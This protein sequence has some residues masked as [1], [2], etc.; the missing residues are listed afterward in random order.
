VSSLVSILLTLCTRD[1]LPGWHRKPTSHI[2][3]GRRLAGRMLFAIGQ[4]LVAGLQ[5]LLT[6]VSHQLV[7][8]LDRL[9]C[10][11]SFLRNLWSQQCKH[12]SS[13]LNLQ[14]GFVKLQDW[15]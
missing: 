3:T 12:L 13:R 14:K 9:T 11:F 1:K 7:H 5:G 4:P 2:L 10:E 6:V 8:L 15:F